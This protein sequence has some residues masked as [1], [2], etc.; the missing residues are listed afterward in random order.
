MNEESLAQVR[1]Q[2]SAA[3]ETLADLAMDALREAIEGDED[4]R[5]QE[6][7]I[8]RARRAVERAVAVLG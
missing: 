6:R 3:A 4:A 8:T 1:D 2:L 5:E 7:R